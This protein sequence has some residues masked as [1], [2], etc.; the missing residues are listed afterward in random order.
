MHFNSARTA[1]RDVSKLQGY[2]PEPDSQ[3]CLLAGS[4][5]VEVMILLDR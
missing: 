4:G 2:S 3:S 1:C 5:V